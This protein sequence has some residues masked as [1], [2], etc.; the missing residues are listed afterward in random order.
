M[1]SALLTRRQA[2][3]TLSAWA[4]AT[5]A[6]SAVAALSLPPGQRRVTLPFE[7]IDNR[8][9][10]QAKVNGRGPLHFI[11]DTGGGNILDTEVARS[12][13]LP[14]QDSFTMPG[15]GDGTLPAWRT[16]VDE[17]QVGALQMQQL[18]FVVLPLQALRRAIGFARLDGLIGH[19]VL[20][21]FVVQ[22]DFVKNQITLSEPDQQANTPA[23]TTALPIE[24]SGNLPLIT[25]HVD[26]VPARMVIDSGDRSSLTLFTPFVDD[27]Q[28]RQAHPRRFAALTGFGVGGPL[29]AEVTRVQELLLGPLPVRGVTTRMPTGRGGVFASRA[30]HASV[31]TGVLKRLDVT[32]DYSQRRVL[33]APNAHHRQPDPVDHSGLWLSQG[34]GVF[35]VEHV[36]ANSAASAAGLRTGDQVLAVDGQAA[37]QILLPELRQRWAAAGPGLA[38]TLTIAVTVDAV[39]AAQTRQRRLKLQD[40]FASAGS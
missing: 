28:L 14:L 26:G 13:G 1:K 25:G 12:L 36:S 20:R 30:A 22:L 21:R 6:P 9:F 31:G 24:F 16:R 34:E 11:F 39:T 35:V 5:S 17:A 10:V 19:E 7:L 27:H 32:F 2:L 8:L 4:A 18:P 37:S 38:I 29:H 3:S 33:L 40:R 15:A 23:G